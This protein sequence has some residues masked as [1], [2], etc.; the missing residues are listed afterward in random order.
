MGIY[1]PELGRPGKNQ[2]AYE[3]GCAQLT[4]IMKPACFWNL[5]DPADIRQ[6]DPSIFRRSLI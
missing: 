4:A 5:N 2:K 1:I 6:L 3:S